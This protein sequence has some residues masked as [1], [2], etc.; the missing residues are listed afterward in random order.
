MSYPHGEWPDP[1]H[2][3]IPNISDQAKQDI[4]LSQINVYAFVG[5]SGT[6][7]STRAIE[8]AA[9]YQI[10]YIIDD[11][12]LIHGSRI[13]A[14]TTAKRAA[15]QLQA[16]RVAIFLEEGQAQTMRRALADRK[17]ERLLILGTSDAMINRICEHLHLTDPVKII[18]IDD[19][20]TADEQRAAKERRMRAGHHT[21][22]VPG[23]EIK[24]EFSGNLM[25]SLGRIFRRQPRDDQ[26]FR[27]LNDRTVVR[28]SFSTLG[29]YSISEEAME[30]LIQYIVDDVPGVDGVSE[31]RFL[32]TLVVS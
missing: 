8:L 10:E 28:P 14:G 13:V 32:L 16:V 12:L 19:V 5:P 31:I 21:I 22:P 6:G 4:I 23:M 29:R 18:R 7:K 2:H 3:S 26:M 17:P 9:K 24:H 11:G 25:G 15:T 27:D 30:H 20:A 1:I